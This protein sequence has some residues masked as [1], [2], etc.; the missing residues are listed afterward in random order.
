MKTKE[1]T[2]KST[3]DKNREGVSQEFIQKMS[4]ELLAIRKSKAAAN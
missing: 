1:N 3:E 4:E 2:K